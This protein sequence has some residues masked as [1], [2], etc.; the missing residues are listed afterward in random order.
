M[1]RCLC[2][3]SSLDAGGAETFLM[4]ISRVLSPDE[5]QLDFIVSAGNG[6]YTKEV[7]ERGGKIYEIPLRTKDFFGAFVGIQSIVKE[8]N[9][10]VVL[11]LG[12]NSLSVMDLIAA[13]L[14][15]AH[16]LALRSC[17]APTDL[18]RNERYVHEFF[19][20]LLNHVVTTK[21]APS[22]LAADFMFGEKSD[23]KLLHN[24]VDLDSFRYNLQDR[25]A[26]RE[27]FGLK[28]KFVVGHVGRFHAQKNHG[29]LLEVFNKIHKQREEAVLLLVGTGPIE[30]QIRERVCTLGLQDYVVF[31]GQ[32]FDI[33][34][35]LSAMDVFVFPSLY[36]GM[37]NTVIE[38]QATGLPCIIADTI[39]SE[40]NLTGLVHYLSLYDDADQWADNIFAAYSNTRVDTSVAFT[41]C[42]YNIRDVA[43]ELMKIFFD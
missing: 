14:G 30:K 5:Y 13:R 11:K 23:V 19:K 32:R 7:L 31:T 25:L 42:G 4:K 41:E 2:I 36:E 10:D 18:S 39:T 1:K 16:H 24:G 8:N 29:Y 38:A 15:G 9:Y 34:A 21:L 22:Q 40:A 37:P 27:E 20:P 17:N 12:E 26:I 6:C 43:K 28:D 3:V 33:P 35:L